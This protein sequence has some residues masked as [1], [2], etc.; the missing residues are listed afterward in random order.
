MALAEFQELPRE[1]KNQVVELFRQIVLGDEERLKWLHETFL[2]VNAHSLVSVAPLKS[3]INAV[4]LKAGVS[5]EIPSSALSRFLKLEHLRPQ[6]AGW[7]TLF[8]LLA[9]EIEICS[10]KTKEIIVRRNLQNPKVHQML[11]EEVSRAVQANPQ[12]STRERSNLSPELKIFEHLLKQGAERMPPRAKNDFFPITVDAPWPRPDQSY[13][14]LFRHST[15]HAAILKT[16]LVI[17]TPESGQVSSW[18]F[19]HFNCGGD[20]E[21]F[22]KNFSHDTMGAIFNFGTTYYF[23]GTIFP[24]H[25]KRLERQARESSSKAYGDD[26]RGIEMICF[27]Q[28]EIVLNLGLFSGVTISQAASG[29]PIVGRVAA[30]HLGSWAKSG[31]KIWDEHVKPTERDDAKFEED[32]RIT[33][34]NL[35]EIGHKLTGGEIAPLFAGAKFNEELCNILSQKIRV[36]IDNRSAGEPREASTQNRGAIETYSEAGP[37]P[38]P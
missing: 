38:R 6:N 31:D 19:R 36:M 21:R 27:E 10:N 37:R 20:E 3:E 28:N 1:Q 33:L 14:L 22:A 18:T 9:P 4:L 15:V 29:Q 35:A 13:Y 11:T 30:L 17:E 25:N 32:L 5:H 26:V 23:L 2:E 24:T 12:S 8:I 34:K 7:F 16:F